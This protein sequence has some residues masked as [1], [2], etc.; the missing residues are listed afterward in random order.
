MERCAVVGFG[1]S[2]EPESHIISALEELKRL[3][4]TAGGYP[5]TSFVQRRAQREPATLIGSGKVVEISREAAR[6]KLDAVVFDVDLTPAQQRNLQEQIPAKILD[7][8]RLILD[9][10]ATRAR[11][12]EGKLQVELAQL[13]YL[14]PRITERFGRFEQQVGGIGTRGPGERKLEVDQRHIRQRIDRIKREIRHIRTQR[15]IQRQNRKRITLPIVAI[16]G[17]TNAGKST[18]LN[19][20]T[21][22][23]GTGVYADDLLFATLDPTTRRVKLPGGRM[24]LFVDT[25]GFIQNLP[26]HLVAAFHATLEEVTDADL[27]VE[28]VDASDVHGAEKHKVVRGVLRDLGAERMPT[29]TALSKADSLSAVQKRGLKRGRLV[30]S[31]RTGEGIPEFLTAVNEAL[32][33]KLATHEFVLPHGKQN[34]LPSIYRAGR[35]LSKK[36]TV[37]GTKIRLRI[38]DKN[39]G[40]IQK[41]LRRR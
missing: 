41:H 4:E 26:H 19:A 14:L 9:I 7:R 29:L 17:Y 25:V 3:L 18:L 13:S 34:L 23:N 39:W 38:D 6:Q 20:L 31:A 8:T 28:L 5:L 11:T 32:D 36:A 24:A 33:A 15:T 40:Q 16:I 12:S 35:V 10:F 30:L 21:G 1:L 27:L 22:A 2:K 37:K